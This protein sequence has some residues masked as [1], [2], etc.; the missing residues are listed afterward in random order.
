[1]KDLPHHM[2]KLNRK[3]IRAEHREEGVIE[4]DSP[5]APRP[6]TEHQIKK[7]AKAQI[8]KTRNARVPIH[9]TEEE[10]NKKMGER[11]PIFD[12]L[13]HSHPKTTRKTRKK[14]PRI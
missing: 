8:T 12:S 4:K 3:V 13:N 5:T 2:N 11:V 9:L 1:M 14:T 10:K 7:Q 6:Q